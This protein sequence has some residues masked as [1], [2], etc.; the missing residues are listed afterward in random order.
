MNPRPLHCESVALSVLTRPFPRRFLVVAFRSLRIPHDPSPSLSIRSRKVT[1]DGSPAGPASHVRSASSRNAQRMAFVPLWRRSRSWA[2]DKTSSTLMLRVTAARK[3]M[4]PMN[5][6]KRN[7]PQPTSLAW[8]TPTAVPFEP[9]Q[10]ARGSLHCSPEVLE[11]V[12]FTQ[13][14]GAVRTHEKR[15]RPGSVRG[16]P[17][18]T[19]RS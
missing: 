16:H 11:G 4:E 9:S 10:A 5:S 13:P 19:R 7:H 2:S 3:T 1:P 8:D 15:P 14:M 6:N 12:S 17:T 18:P